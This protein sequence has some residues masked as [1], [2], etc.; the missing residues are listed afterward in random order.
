MEETEPPELA[1]GFNWAQG[2]ITFAGTAGF[3]ASGYFFAYHIYFMDDDAAI[4]GLILVLALFYAALFTLIALPYAR[5]IVTALGKPTV[6]RI[7]GAGLYYAF[8]SDETIPWDKVI[9]VS[10]TKNPLTAAFNVYVDPALPIRASLLT[11]LVGAADQNAAAIASN[12]VAASENEVHMALTRYLPEE[13][14][15]NMPYWTS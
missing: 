13:K 12:V 6:L 5:F 8:A 2:L 11:K 1:C 7:G 14:R 4:L 9:A 15:R 3:A 10:K